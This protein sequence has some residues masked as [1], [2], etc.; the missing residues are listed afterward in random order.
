[1]LL[2]SCHWPRRT[3]FILGLASLFFIL[4]LA[5]FQFQPYPLDPISSFMRLS[6]VPPS[7][8]SAPEI[9]PIPS[10]CSTLSFERRQESTNGLAI[11]L[12][13]A[14]LLCRTI[15]P[16]APGIPKLLHQSWK[17]NE[18]PAKFHKWSQGCREKHAGWEWVLWTDDDNLK[19]VQM[20]FPWLEEIYT[21]LPGP[22]YRADFTRNLYMYMFGG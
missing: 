22:I 3:I 21:E 17:N 4:I 14:E 9:P 12:S 15:D 16:T 18:L 11:A 7:P 5:V 8:P 19:L 10:E 13:P 6:V 1:M 20:Y 2:R